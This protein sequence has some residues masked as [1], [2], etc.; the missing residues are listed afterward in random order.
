MLPLDVPDSGPSTHIFNASRMAP[1]KWGGTSNEG[2]E[3]AR[4][5]EV[6]G[7]EDEESA[8]YGKYH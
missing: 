7:V 3:D 8:L 5:V 1:L 2:N 6:E 4:R